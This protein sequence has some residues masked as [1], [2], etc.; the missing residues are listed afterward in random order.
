LH[1]NLQATIFTDNVP[2]FTVVTSCAGVKHDTRI[3]EWCWSPVYRRCWHEYSRVS[4]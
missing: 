4:M 3:H 2:K 1:N